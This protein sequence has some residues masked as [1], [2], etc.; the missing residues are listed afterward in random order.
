MELDQFLGQ[1]G[2]DIC[3]LTENHIRSGEVFRMA[4]YVTAPTNELKEAEELYCSIA[5]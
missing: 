5:A 4:N 2:I 3:L 1:N